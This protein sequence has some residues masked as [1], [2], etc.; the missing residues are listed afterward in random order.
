MYLQHC[1]NTAVWYYI[2]CWIFLL[3]NL[4]LYFLWK[5]LLVQ[6]IRLISYDC[7]TL[8]ST[9]LT[10][11]S[12]NYTCDEYILIGHMLPVGQQKN[13]TLF[14]N[15]SAE[16]VSKSE[17]NGRLQLV[18]RLTVTVPENASGQT[19]TV[20]CF[21]SSDSEDSRSISFQVAIGVSDS[22]NACGQ[23]YLVWSCLCV[24]HCT[25]IIIMYC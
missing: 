16:L 14:P 23:P 5:E 22:R 9:N 4:I 2:F 15:T 20:T 7:V 3:Q 6:E 11:I 25:S 1:M 21:Y 8:D 24:S 18:S 10:W 13:S 12:D 17:V 19:H